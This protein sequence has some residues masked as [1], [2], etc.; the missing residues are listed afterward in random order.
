M[1]RSLVHSPAAMLSASMLAA[2]TVCPSHATPKVALKPQFRNAPPPA[3]AYRYPAPACPSPR[4]GGPHHKAL[5]PVARQPRVGQMV[6]RPLQKL[7][8]R[9]LRIVKLA[10]CQG[11]PFAKL[12][13]V[14]IEHREKKSLLVAAR[15]A[16]QHQRIPF[17]NN[18]GCEEMI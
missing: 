15:P 7:R 2:C 8:D 3:R 17:S 12:G 18:S 13:S 9:L 1:R 14:T 6:G 4:R 11:Q 16:V 10:E 5:F